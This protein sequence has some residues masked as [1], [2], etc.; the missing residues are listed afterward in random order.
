MRETLADWNLNDS[1]PVARCH[2]GTDTLTKFRIHCS[3]SLP[4]ASHVILL[5]CYWHLSQ[6]VLTTWAKQE[7]L[8]SDGLLHDRDIRGKNHKRLRLKLTKSFLVFWAQGHHHSF[9][10]FPNG[11][12]SVRA[13]GNSNS[14]T[15][16]PLNFYGISYHIFTS[17]LT[18]ISLYQRNTCGFQ[19]RRQ[20]TRNKFA[21]K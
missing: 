12:P 6:Y 11:S 17:L 7:G 16:V 18:V 10:R 14:G 13:Q 4:R 8:F 9:I 3:P 15:R 19:V 21:W 1:S 2:W 5:L 20:A